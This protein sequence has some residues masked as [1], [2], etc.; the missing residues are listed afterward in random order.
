ML[1]P[2]R[3]SRSGVA[4]IVAMTV[5]V[6]GLLGPGP[7]SA[8]AVG[9][10]SRAAVGPTPTYVPLAVPQ[11]ALDTRANSATDD[12]RFAATGRLSAGRIQLMTIA[13]RF[14][15]PNSAEAVTINL[16]VTGPAADGW[17][18]IWPCG[19]A[20]PSTS[21]I[22]F[23]V[24][25]DAA[26]A[27]VVRVGTAGAL[28]LV[29]SVNAD[30]VIDVSG[31]FPAGSSLQTLGAPVRV[32]DTRVG[33]ATDDHWYE[34][35]G[36]R[37]AATPL[38]L[39]LAGRLG[40][41]PDAGAVLITITVVEAA[42]GGYA[43]VWPCTTTQPSTSN[44]NFGTDRAVANGVTMSL[45]PSGTICVRTSVEVQVIVDVT[46]YFPAGVYAGLERPQ[47]LMDTRAGAATDDG[48]FQRGGVVGAQ[49]RSV[50]I[51]GRLGVPAN[52]SVVVLNVTVVG[53]QAGGWL[54]AYPCGTPRPATSTLNYRAGDVVANSVITRVGTGGAVCLYAEGSTDVIVDAM[55]VL[56][57]N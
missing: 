2:F 29:S 45:S 5:A 43:T 16:T 14:G 44:I 36:R 35:I 18:V 33:S 21:N 17:A 55:G 22:N 9:A 15:I 8:P 57:S 3:R 32:L 31:Y 11:R 13:G 56:V 52:A 26:N 25:R 47:R 4:A 37:L 54:V 19:T 48:R 42:S 10:P 49:E 6:L 40:V 38:S 46:G 12:G 23:G 34:G 24:N 30:F 7:S 39:N 20:Q 51:A 41:P 50:Q 27:A 28:C 1:R 53:P